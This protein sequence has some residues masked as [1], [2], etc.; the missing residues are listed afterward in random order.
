MKKSFKKAGAA[1]LSMTMLLSMGAVSMPVFAAD[2]VK[3]AQVTVKIQGVTG[4]NVDKQGE[5][6]RDAY[7]KKLAVDGTTGQPILD[8]NGKPTYA[9]DANGYDIYVDA[10]GNDIANGT[11]GKPSDPSKLVPVGDGSDAAAQ[12]ALGSANY[13]PKYDYLALD[14][15]ED[16]TVTLY[17]VAQLNSTN[18]WEWEDYIKNYNSSNPMPDF[19]TFA[20]LLAN[21][22]GRT[23]IADKSTITGDY[24]FTT[25]S[26]LLQQMASQ[27]E[28][29]I[30]ALE[31][32]VADGQEGARDKLN[33]LTV[34]SATL[35][36]DQ[37]ANGVTLPAIDANALDRNNDGVLS[38]AEKA[39]TQN[40]I[41]YYLLV[42]RTDQSGVIVQPVLLCLKNGD[43]KTVAMKGT[44]IEFEKTMTDIY[45]TEEQ[46]NKSADTDPDRFNST[47]GANTKNGLVAMGDIVKYQ[48]V[49]R[50]PKYDANVRS[51]DITDF[52]IVD[53]ASDGITLDY[54][55][56]GDGATD[57]A[58]I[59]D[60]STF[61]VYLKND[62]SETDTTKM[63][64]LTGSTRKNVGD[65]QLVVDEDGHGFKL[66]ITGYQMRESDNYRNKNVQGGTS[67]EVRG[68]QISDGEVDDVQLITGHSS[69]AQQTMAYATRL[70]Q[71]TT[72]DPAHTAANPSK[73]D[74]MENKYIYINFQ[75]TVD[76]DKDGKVVADAKKTE[77]KAD[78]GYAFRRSFTDYIDIG[79]VTPAMMTDAALGETDLLDTD[80]GYAASLA[81]DVAKQVLRAKLF[82]ETR[83]NKD[84]T[85]NTATSVNDFSDAAFRKMLL[86]NPDGDVNEGNLNDTGKKLLAN[87]G[88]L[89]EVKKYFD[90]LK[91]DVS[92]TET[93]TYDKSQTGATVKTD[94]TDARIK[95]L[96]ARDK[97]NIELNGEYNTAHMTYGNRYATGKGNAKLNTNY[98]KVYSVDL[99]LDKFIETL[100]VVGAPSVKNNATVYGQ[101][102]T[103]NKTQPITYTY[104]P[105]G[106]TAPVTVTFTL[107][108]LKT[109]TIDDVD[110][111]LPAGFATMTNAQLAEAVN[112]VAGTNYA[113]ADL[114]DTTAA[115]GT[116]DKDKMTQAE[117]GTS[118]EPTDAQKAAAYLIW[119]ATNANITNSDKYKAATAYATAN[120]ASV[121]TFN[122]TYST[123]NGADGKT[124]QNAEA[125]GVWGGLNDLQKG[126]VN[127]LINND[128]RDD[129]GTDNY[130]NRTKKEP[131]T[132]AVFHLVRNY[133]DADGNAQV[134]DLG[135]AVSAPDGSLQKLIIADSAPTG[136]YKEYE[137]KDGDTLKKG[138]V[139][140]TTTGTAPNQVT[141]YTG[142]KVW[143]ELDIGNY[144]IYELAVPTGFKKWDKATFTISAD[145][146]DG[147]YLQNGAW[148]GSYKAEA[149]ISGEASSTSTGFGSIAEVAGGTGKAQFAYNKGTGR[150]SHDL[151]NEY[152]DEL[153]ATGGMGTVLFTAGGIAV[154]LMAGALFVVYMK[155]RNAEEEE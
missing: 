66:I 123:N 134:E 40:I 91:Y 58:S 72:E 36:N 38:D 28:R 16:A 146:D 126:L 41:G 13:A 21:N 10:D 32:D 97:H 113:A 150:L 137:F 98:S 76:K 47:A 92:G 33:A 12:N 44:T 139:S 145:T 149:A 53:T 23:D 129:D 42:T 2:T 130:L 9:K 69:D 140:Y 107:E 143:R 27:L 43:K 59:I 84:Y 131:V 135:Y 54:T 15:I 77:T 51:G 128:G 18:G 25:S 8:S 3:P 152:L 148:T 68:Q 153:P 90:T 120:S 99:S 50:L 4:N 6:Q 62:K 81:A 52:V 122:Y 124:V 22:D 48:I 17:R 121:P 57:E 63:W 95:L 65:Y 37:L 118:A 34:A 7:K 26:V 19:P 155:K 103:Y 111:V 87:L 96:L 138:Y 147:T 67:E 14:G 31:K 151:Y 46:R 117:L 142:D 78:G 104:T 94:K 39:A 5:G 70:D 136:S 24:E 141:T 83:Y 29:A 73:M 74:T 110:K 71:T 106:A 11:D 55:V 1:V 35:T 101:Y 114:I 82:G 61:E 75:A 154:I 79:D 20:Q 127:Y 85:G 115:Y 119:K 116:G 112:N 93:E 64:K 86:T 56:S 89:D 102:Y 133:T 125:E 45:S 30:T 108:D 144:T 100:E 80:T 88:S 49:S 132:G 105:T 109:Y 60:P